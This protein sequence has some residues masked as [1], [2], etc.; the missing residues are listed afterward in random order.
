MGMT[1]VSLDD[2]EARSSEATTEMDRLREILS[3]PSTDQ[4]IRAMEIVMSEGS[5]EQKRIALEASLASTSEA[6]RRTGIEAYL[7]AKPLIAFSFDGSSLSGT[8]LSNFRRYFNRNG[9]LEANELGRFAYRVGGFLPEKACWPWAVTPENCM[10]RL[11]DETVILYLGNQT[12]GIGAIG[13]DGTV[14]GNATI[15]KS[16]TVPYS[17]SVK[18]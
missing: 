5:I 12:S 8:Y 2:L 3:S 6:V 13:K 9:T 11:T 1:Q 4:A 10:F 17:F 16:G 7:N 14:R 15:P 18:F